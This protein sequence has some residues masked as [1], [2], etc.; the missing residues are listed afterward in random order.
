[1]KFPDTKQPTSRDN[2]PLRLSRL[3]PNLTLE[4]YSRA[5]IQ[6]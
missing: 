6:T 2:A 4:G 1:M 5:A 3:S